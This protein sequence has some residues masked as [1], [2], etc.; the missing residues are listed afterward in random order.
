MLNISYKSEIIVEIFFVEMFI[1]TAASNHKL[2]S[3]AHDSIIHR[4]DV[5]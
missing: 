3:S 4:T 1:H 2:D 5:E